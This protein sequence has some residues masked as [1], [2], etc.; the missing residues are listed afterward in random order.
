VFR[1]R[2]LSAAADAVARD[3]L[4]R[5]VEYART[6]TALYAAARKEAD[7]AKKDIAAITA[8]VESLSGGI[9]GAR[10]VAADLV[11]RVE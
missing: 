1:A 2:D 4:A 11:G 8:V 7:A 3:A 9:S 6:S 10:V 5:E